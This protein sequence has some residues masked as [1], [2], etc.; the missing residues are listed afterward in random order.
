MIIFVVDTMIGAHI[1]EF[2]KVSGKKII[3]NQY[4]LNFSE[5]FS[6]IGSQCASWMPI[7]I[8]SPIADDFCVLK[9]LTVLEL[10][11]GNNGTYSG[12]SFSV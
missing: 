10:W 2:Y 7:L 6:V 11:S 9:A 4:F 1:F 8:S 12:K 3:V 5:H